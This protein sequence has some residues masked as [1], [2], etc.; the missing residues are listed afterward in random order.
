MMA[1]DLSV[2]SSSTGREP[3]PILSDI[4]QIMPAGTGVPDIALSP[5]NPVSVCNGYL[6]VLKDEV[7]ILE[8]DQFGV[9][10][11]KTYNWE[12]KY[13]TGKIQLYEDDDA[14]S[15]TKGFY[16]LHYS[17]VEGIYCQDLNITYF[18]DN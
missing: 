18:K 6:N 3:P 4:L 13:P 10:R 11:F 5:I 14:A 9:N 15:Q 16:Y 17:N 1:Q 12:W 8:N 2:Q 7:H